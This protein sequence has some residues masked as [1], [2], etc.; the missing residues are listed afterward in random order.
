M[1]VCFGR[2]RHFIRPL[3]FLRC[4]KQES[5]QYWNHPWLDGVALA[6]A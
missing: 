6:L 3:P 5:L 2:M 1:V 4:R